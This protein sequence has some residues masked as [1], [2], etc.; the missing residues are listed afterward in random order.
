MST[1]DPIPFPRF[2]AQLAACFAI[3]AGAQAQFPWT[4]QAPMPTS[5]DLRAVALVSATE[6]WACGGD[7][8]LVHT[9][10]AGATWELDTLN[11]DSI[12]AL[13][14]V[15]AQHGWA[16]GNG[17]FHTVN[18]GQ[19][20]IHDSIWGSIYD[21]HFIDTQR[22]W[23]CGNGS[24][25]YRTT[26]G[27]VSW[28][29]QPLGPSTTLSSIWFVDAANGWTVDIDGLIHQSVDGGVSW[30]LRHDANDYLSTVQFFDLLEG[31]AIGGDSFLHTV[32]GG[33][34]W[35]RA[36]VP[37]GTWSHAAR[38]SDPQHGISVG[39]SGNVLITF[40]FGQTWTTVPPLTSDLLWDVESWD[41][42][43][44]VAAGSNGALVRTTD[45]GASWTSLQSGGWTPARCTA[46]ATAARRRARAAT[47]VL[48]RTV[49]PARRTPPAR[50][51]AR[52]ARRAWLPIRSS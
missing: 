14:F 10:D 24:V 29:Y 35:T 4:R 5:S 18:G 27:G 8:E 11:T 38:F 50:T 36:T 34:T 19:T 40:D 47:P 16:A 9:R 48:P 41:A 46:R 28:A 15:D 30:T 37:A 25:T 20:W 43:I 6:L 31:W 45:G 52:P 49:A 23:A 1:R 32:D 22:G 42:S 39:Q 17:F 2:V 13:D 3:E 12:W 44:S 51:S 26:N 33:Q 21:V 7:G